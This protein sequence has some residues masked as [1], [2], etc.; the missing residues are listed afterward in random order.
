M[1]SVRSLAIGS[2]LVGAAFT[3]S[4]SNEIP[5]GQRLSIVYGDGA[6][7]VHAPGALMHPGRKSYS[8]HSVGYELMLEDMESSPNISTPSWPSSGGS[9]VLIMLDLDAPFENTRVSSLHWLVTGVTLTNEAM[10][11]SVA[12]L[13]ELNKP[14]PQVP[15]EKPEP[16]I[17]SRSSAITHILLFLSNKYQGDVAHTYAFYLFAPTPPSFSIPASYGNLAERRTPFDLTQFLRDCG[18]EEQSVIARNHFRVRNL[19]GT[20]T[21]AFPPPRVSETAA[22]LSS[23]VAPSQTSVVFQGGSV[24]L[25]AEPIALV[26]MI[27]A[28]LSASTALI[29]K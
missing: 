1:L 18:L 26:G 16:P 2:L 17:V 20:P 6:R 15:Y 5:I 3:Q 13:V 27:T 8:C 19:A 23:A 4:V 24:K 7:T 11:P 28:L 29:L 9:G 25:I 22:Q 21:G 12:N 10:S 14:S